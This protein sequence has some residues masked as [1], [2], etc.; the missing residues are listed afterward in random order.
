MGV[1]VAKNGKITKEMFLSMH[2][3]CGRCA[4]RPGDGGS[5]YSRY[6]IR[7]LAGKPEAVCED[8]YREFCVGFGNMLVMR[9]LARASR[10]ETENIEESDEDEGVEDEDILDEPEEEEADADD[11]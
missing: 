10:F 7:N 6:V 8:H 2:P 9:S 4:D 11:E 3:F 1:P 5:G